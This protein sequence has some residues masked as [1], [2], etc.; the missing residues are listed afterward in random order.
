[1]FIRNHCERR[2]LALR[3]DTE[4]RGKR[5]DPVAMA[6]PHLVARTQRP[7][8]VKQRRL[9]RDLDLGAAEFALVVMFDAPAQLHDHGLL[10][11]ADAE[12]RDAKLEHGFRCARAAL[13]AYAGRTA[14][15]DY[16]AGP[17]VL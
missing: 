2:V 11:V 5:C 9:P 10:A 4:A 15:E 1:A 14:G 12:N 17:P 16:R 13:I 8:A 3:D 6:H 7:K